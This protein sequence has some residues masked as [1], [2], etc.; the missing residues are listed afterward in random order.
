MLRQ[1]IS[2]GAWSAGDNLPGEET[3][4]ASYGVSR[5]TIR[6]AVRVLREEGLVE[7]RKGAGSI[8]RS[9][10][11][12]I[13]IQASA[14]DVVTARM[15]TP[16]EQRALGI[17]DGVPVISVKRPGAAEELFDGNRAEITLAP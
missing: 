10:P 11:R 12:R 14:D 13:Q 4:S 8:V 6:E 1:E 15:P 7:T 9:V 16:A 17:G 3:L 2:K 5:F